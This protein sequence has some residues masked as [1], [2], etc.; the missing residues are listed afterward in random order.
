MKKII[1]ASLESELSN[2]DGWNT[3][4]DSIYELNSILDEA[5]NLKYEI[6]NCVRG[7]YTKCHTLSELGEYVTELGER[8]SYIGDC[9]SED[10]EEY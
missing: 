7:A 9:I 1:K 3:D 10:S 2:N 4:I 5:Y 6:E 8:L